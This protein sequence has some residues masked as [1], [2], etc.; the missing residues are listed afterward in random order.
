MSPAGLLSD[1]GVRTFLLIW[2]G[3]FVSLAGSGLTR[4]ALGVW[5]YERSGSV[6]YFAFTML[7]GFLPGLLLTPVAGMMVDRW[8]RRRTIICCEI[9][10]SV[11]TL[12]I[13]VLLYTGTFAIW[14]LCA[15]LVVSASFSAF[16]GVASSAIVAMLVPKQHFGRVSGLMMLGRP[17]TRIFSPMLAGMLM[18]VVQIETIVLID[19]VTFLAPILVFAFVRIPA[20]EASAEALAARKSTWLEISS[21]WRFIQERRGV[22]SLF[23]YFCVLNL[24]MGMARALYR[25]MVLNFAS[26]E[27]VG[28][29]SAIA[30]S[31]ALA[32]A[33]FMMVWGG[34]RRVVQG[35]LGYGALYSLGLMLLGSRPEPLLV[36]F[37][38][39]GLL[40][41]VP[42]IVGSMRAIWM[43]K[44]PADMQG[45]VFA[46]WGTMGQVTMLLAY[47]AAGPIADEVFE[48]LLAAGGG[49]AASVGQV[50][51]VGPGRGIGL[52]YIVIG[53]LVLSATVVAALDPRLRRMEEELPDAI[54]DEPSPATG[55]GFP[56]DAEAVSP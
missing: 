28:V 22:L 53:F 44:T 43:R 1:R 14:N 18:A 8:D 30:A 54:A 9:G 56:R 27:V 32:G 5:I 49:L 42:V 10:R 19:F 33:V 48:P 55:G 34:P 21:G 38:L 29:I 50:I 36:G 31:G 13:A 17:S 47:V 26:V 39:C 11:G 24:S 52:L 12:A 3:Q 4:F 51:G 35:I 6:T 37:T 25:P 41:G 2:L 40:F 46:A 45:R 20:P 15:A 16:R 23:L 7:A